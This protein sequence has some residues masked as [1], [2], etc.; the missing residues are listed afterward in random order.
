MS[1]GVP[2]AET[3]CGFIAEGDY[4][5]QRGT[6]LALEG[7]KQVEAR[8]QF[9]QSLRIHIHL[10]RIPGEVCGEIANRFCKPLLLFEE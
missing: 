8:F 2:T 4:F 1:E 5:R 3:R 7:L 9:L 10:V 6:K